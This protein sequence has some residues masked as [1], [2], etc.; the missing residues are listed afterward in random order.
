[1]PEGKRISLS[2]GIIFYNMATTLNFLVINTYSTLTL[3]VADTSTYD[4]SPTGA[5]MLIT[6]PTG[7]TTLTGG[8]TVTVPFTPNDYNVFNSATL[9]LSAVGV[10]NPLPDGIYGLRYSIATP[11]TPPVSKSIM[12][13]AKIQEKFDNAFMKLDMMECDMAIKTQQK[14][15]LSSIYFLIQ[16]STAAANNLA[17]T[18]S[19]KLYQQANMMLDN[20]L[21][22]NCGCSGNNYIVNFQ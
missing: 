5:S 21:L 19:A 12:R 6:L 22:N 11:T 14:V 15:V 4:S 10:T 3:G 17:Y 1:M 18:Q 16:G 2:S 20:F 9:Q 8:T 13:T 7:V